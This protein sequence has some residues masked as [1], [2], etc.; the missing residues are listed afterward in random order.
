MNKKRFPYSQLPESEIK[1]LQEFSNLCRRDVLTMTTLAGSGHPGG[2]MSAM[3]IY[4]V[5]FHYAA[6][7]PDAPDDPERDKIVVSFGHTSPGVYAVLGRLGFFDLDT[8]IASFRQAGSIFEGHI[9]R[10]V[11][12]VEW[13]TGNLGQGLSAGCGFALIDKIKNRD[14]FT[15]VLMSDGEQTKGQVGEA[16]RFAIKYKLNNLRVIIDYNRIQISGCIFD[17]MPNN[18]KENYLADGWEVM[19]TDGHDISDLYDTIRRSLEIDKPVCIIASTVI[20]KGVS[21]MEGKCAYHGKVLK[22]DEYMKAVEELGLCSELEKYREIRKNKMYSFPDRTFDIKISALQGSIRVYQPGTKIDN[23]TA[24]GNALLDIGIANKDNKDNPVIV[25]DCDLAS[26]VKTD[27]FAKQFPERFFQCGVQEHHAATVAGAASVDGAIS[28][29]ADFGVF[30]VD[31]TYN[32]HRLNDQNYT[33]LKIVCTH[34]GLDVGEDGK[35]HQCIDYVGLFRNVF[36]IRLIIP[37]DANQTDRVIRYVATHPGN[38]FVGMGRSYTPI[39]TTSDG[40][41]FFGEKYQFEY[42]KADILRDGKHGFIYT[43]GALVPRAVAI[44]DRL[45]QDGVSIGVINCSC[46][47]IIDRE[48]M[49]LGIK[50]GLIIS[51]EDH[52]VDSGLGMTIAAYIAE[53]QV[54]VKFHRFGI[55]KYG[56]SGTPDE[57]Y[58]EH[59]LDP[60]TMIS[61]IKSIIKK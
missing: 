61:F 57:L 53:K 30:G 3:E 19:E 45:R 35:T 21:F 20:G 48:A 23:R 31:E 46:P 1:K 56:S 41:P 15:F 10:K 29:F 22:E 58:A 16:R 42:G 60:E 52:V 26:S 27:L 39:I 5:V 51:Y 7:S 37:A 18:I 17:I 54:N 59:G 24:F 28:F 49:E 6:I 38:Y 55:R 47:V 36:G 33:N 50:T 12:G 25:F 9:V 14:T 11:P 44:S 32:Q 40:K 8:A 4:N 43:L 34:L 13:G 2:S